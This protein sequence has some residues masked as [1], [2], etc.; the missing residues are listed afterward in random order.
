VGQ[1]LGLGLTIT[2][3]ALMAMEGRVSM[4]NVS[5]GTGVRVTLVLKAAMRLVAT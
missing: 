4:D 2:R 1:G 5:K 3:E